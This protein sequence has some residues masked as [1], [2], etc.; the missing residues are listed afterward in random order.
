MKLQRL[1]LNVAVVALIVYVASFV[2][3]WLA[4]NV[5]SPIIN[6]TGNLMLDSLLNVVLI[7]LLL[8]AII[9]RWKMAQKAV[10]EKTI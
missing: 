6:P 8:V 7:A 4:D 9:S 5:V 10:T 3:G 2:T 1:G